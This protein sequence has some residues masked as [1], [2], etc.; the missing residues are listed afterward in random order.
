MPPLANIEHG[1]RDGSSFCST[2]RSIPHGCDDHLCM[3]FK[4]TLC[5]G[6]RL[7]IPHYALPLP[8]L[9]GCL[10]PKLSTR[11]SRSLTSSP[12]SVTMPHSAQAEEET[13]SASTLPSANGT[14]KASGGP[15]A[16][17]SA[18]SQQQQNG[19]G[20]VQDL[21]DLTSR[22]V[23]APLWR[24]NHSSYSQVWNIYFICNGI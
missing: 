15:G 10:R 9:F 18:Q 17:Y 8:A 3:I 20:S 2:L 6:S 4:D 21:R 24:T 12:S 11:H 5:E 19:G 16:K 7:P 13:S 22:G 1:E 14:R 23:C